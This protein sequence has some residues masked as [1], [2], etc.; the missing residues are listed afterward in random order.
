M[1]DDGRSEG[2][3][4]RMMNLS[5][6]IKLMAMANNIPIMSISAVTDDEGKKRMGPPRVSQVAWSR[7]LEYDANLIIAV[8]KHEDTNLIQ[9]VSRKVRNGKPFDFVLDVDFDRGIWVEKA[10][11]EVML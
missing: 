9:V 6:E 7:G 11:H 4:P 2:M 3:T 8:H 1:M 5:R 10:T